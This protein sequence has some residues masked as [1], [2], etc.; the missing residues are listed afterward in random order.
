MRATFAIALSVL[1]AA[2]AAPFGVG[3]VVVA[4]HIGAC[5]AL[6]LG[7]VAGW[8]G[9]IAA[10]CAALAALWFLEPAAPVAFLVG[11]GLGCLAWNL[12]LWEQ[13][14]FLDDARPWSRL[15][16]QI[17]EAINVFIR[18][19]ARRWDRMYAHG[20]W[21]F[22]HDTKLA[23]L[24]GA[25]ADFLRLRAPGGARVVDLGCGNGAL[26]SVPRGWHQG[27]LGIDLSCEAVA[28]CPSRLGFRSD[29]AFR[30]G[31]VEDFCDFANF[32][33]AV[34]NEML[35]YLSIDEATTA[36]KNAVDGLRAPATVVVV[37][38][39]NPKARRIWAGLDAWRAPE[40]AHAFRVV[41]QEPV[42][43]VRLYM[44]ATSLEAT[45]QP[46]EQ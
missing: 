14:E 20:Q 6:A 16:H 22:L 32:E 15:R 19:D 3:L 7:R 39:D 5:A 35:Y 21:E 38:T 45:A 34:F 11:A 44:T 40:N 36:V 26:L 37:M 8:P 4:G 29:E 17:D 46:V 33:A 42:C 41:P 12:S 24:Y 10:G 28:G 18:N 27:Y 13:M 9:G 31:R 30:V 43:E 23:P 2:L 25:A 1:S